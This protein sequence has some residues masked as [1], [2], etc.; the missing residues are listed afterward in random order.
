M[1]LFVDLGD[2]DGLHPVPEPG[3]QEV[4]VLHV[5][6]CFHVAFCKFGENVGAEHICLGGEGPGIEGVPGF[7]HDESAL[8]HVIHVLH[9]TDAGMRKFKVVVAVDGDSLQMIPICDSGHK[10][11][12]A[13]GVFTDDGES[14]C[15]SSACHG[16]TCSGCLLCFR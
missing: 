2:E 16:F 9:G 4:H 11:R 5:K 12:L 13:C 14:S 3:I 15:L 8:L 6:V 10:R 1:V 7:I